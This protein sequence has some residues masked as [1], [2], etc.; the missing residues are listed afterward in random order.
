VSAEAARSHRRLAAT[1][2]AGIGPDALAGEPIAPGTTIVIAPYVLHRHRLLWNDPDVF[3]PTR[4]LPGARET[5]D[6]FG[7]LPF[8]A[9]PRICIGAIFALQEATLVV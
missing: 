6:R 5:I 7:Y 4:F 2:G 9:G 1:S 8:G 3:D